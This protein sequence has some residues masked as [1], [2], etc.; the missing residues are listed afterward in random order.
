MKILAV[1]FCSI[2]IAPAHC[3]P[4]LGRDDAVPVML[5]CIAHEDAAMKFCET[6][7]AALDGAAGM[8]RIREASAPA[9]VIVCV[10]GKVS[11]GM[12]YTRMTVDAF[13]QMGAPTYSSQ[14]LESPSNFD[15]GRALA[16]RVLAAVRGAS[17][18][19]L[20]K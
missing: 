11:G 2:L 1:V 18:K 6:V 20:R 16:Q 10:V 7:N 5:E 15:D 13:R 19:Y 17:D 12:M 3:K 8:R 9:I 4:V 14:P